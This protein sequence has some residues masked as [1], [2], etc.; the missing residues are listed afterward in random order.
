MREPPRLNSGVGTYSEQAVPGAPYQNYPPPQRP[1][2]GA[3]KTIVLAFVGTF[4]GMML[5][6][7]GAVAWLY[8][9]FNA[10][11][12]MSAEFR[13][14]REP[15]GGQMNQEIVDVLN[16]AQPRLDP[17]I[18]SIEPF[19]AKIADG[20]YDDA[21]ELVDY[22]RIV[23]EMQASGMAVG[24]NPLTKMMWIED[25]PYSFELPEIGELHQVVDFRW[26][27]PGIEARATLVHTRK[28]N[29]QA[30][31]LLLYVT[32]KN[33]SWK[34]YDYR[35]VLLPFS[36]AQYF[37][38]Y[39]AV[40][41]SARD[42]YYDLSVELLSIYSN[43]KIGKQQQAALSLQALNRGR[44]TKSVFP[45][46]QSLT[47]GYLLLYGDIPTLAELTNSMDD[48]A[49]AG[50]HRFKAELALLQDKPSD[51]FSHAAELIKNVGWHPAA[52]TL[53]GK[54]AETPEHRKQAAEWLQ[55]SVVLFPQK[56]AWVNAFVSMSSTSDLQQLFSKFSTLRNG[57][58]KAI[59]FIGNMSDFSE[60]HVSR[61]LEANAGNVDEFKLA[62]NYL[63][64]RQSQ[65]LDDSAKTIEFAGKILS[66]PHIAE[67]D[68]ALESEG[69]YPLLSTV[70]N[71]ILNEM[72]NAESFDLA[73][74]IAPDPT[75]FARRMRDRILDSWY[76]TMD[77]SRAV[78]FLES[79]PV[80]SEIAAEVE[81]KVAI[82]VCNHRLEK[83]SVAFEQLL[84]IISE[85]RE[86]ITSYD[87]APSYSYVCVDA[88]ANCAVELGEIS[89]FAGAIN[90]PEIAFV[91]LQT[92][93]NPVDHAT[94]MERL[95]EWYREATDAPAFWLDYFVAE[96]RFAQGDWDNADA[97]LG[98]AIEAANADERLA[99][100]DFPPILNDFS[101]ISD[102]IDEWFDLRVEYALRSGRFT[103]LWNHAKEAMEIDQVVETLR[104]RLNYLDDPATCLE[105]AELMSADPASEF[106]AVGKQARRRHAELVGDL[107][108]ALDMAIASALEHDSSQGDWNSDFESVV[109]LMVV[110]DD[111]G[112]LGSLAN[113]SSSTDQKTTLLILQAYRERNATRM[114]EAFQQYEYGY[115]SSNWF[116]NIGRIA[117]LQSAAMWSELNAKYPSSVSSL[118]LD[119]H[120]VCTLGLD[121][122][123]SAQS[124]AIATVVAECISSTA[125]ELDIAAFPQAVG[126]WS[127]STPMGT[128]VAVSYDQ[129]PAIDSKD[130]DLQKFRENYQG[131][132]CLALLQKPEQ[133]SPSAQ[134]RQIA[135]DVAEKLTSAAS[136][137]DH[138]AASWFTEPDWP[139]RLREAASHGI[140]RRAPIESYMPNLADEYESSDE[141]LYV[142]LGLIV[143]AITVEPPPLVEDGSI[144]PA[145]T[146]DELSI[147]SPVFQLR[148]TPTLIP[149]LPI[150]SHITE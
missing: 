111:F 53:A 42:S 131:L 112:A 56:P 67:L 92:Y 149:C 21:E 57:Q 102:S 60:S 150:G 90:H 20:N 64:F 44:I 103:D 50:S 35:D 134:L 83:Y 142:S 98:R 105:I 99:E 78:Q 62:M 120:A 141:Q 30:D 12:E 71:G 146:A 47:A 32:K 22:A 16:A 93:L 145:D 65:Q 94:E 55:R 8:Y 52:A 148:K 43:D 101:P 104:W 109:Q 54:S 91:A 88:A 38:A 96:L 119:Y 23:E 121:Q 73:L 25:L 27:V 126:A 79:L 10:P 137:F 82:A 77:W 108:A 24:I 143:E 147:D 115:T 3:G 135:A 39:S 7:G 85:H 125:T 86:R 122:A 18:D 29:D 45:L 144:D 110:Q 127:Y 70:W 13:E 113:I 11:T 95:N 63:Q 34:I 114:L 58:V 81:T 15:V 69:E 76:L 89:A 59:Q 2:S 139:T 124:D 136:Y 31:V 133:V 41:I 116:N 75:E 97:S 17:D 106:I 68:A 118:V 123:A 66:D 129:P 26:L 28:W 140:N 33:G 100:F 61:I 138:Q 80:D 128:L 84:A 132:L 51:A 37:A 87:V 130:D 14:Q 72:E 49:F 6:C 1:P 40:P 117:A 46:A 107:G 4:M 48:K 19:I 36:E 5:L 9:A 74:S